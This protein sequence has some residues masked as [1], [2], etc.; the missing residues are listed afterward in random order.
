M[1]TYEVGQTIQWGLTVTDADGALADPG[2]GPTGT[3][4]LPDGTTAAATVAR[5]S[6]GL[7]TATLVSTQAG[8]HRLTWAGSGTN[9]GGFPYTDVADVW[10]SDPRL[11]IGLADARAALNIPATITVNDDELRLHIAAATPV[12]EDI[13]GPVLMGSR[14]EIWSG[15]GKMGLALGAIPTAIT[16]VVEDSV[17]LAASAY[18]FDEDGVLW[19]G[20]AP[21]AGYWSSAS[22]RNVVVTYTVG[23]A[24]IPPN[25]VAAA[26]EEVRFLYQRQQGQRP[27][28]NV[29]E[30]GMAFTP[31]G[32]AVPRFVLELCKPSKAG[33]MPG[34]A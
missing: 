33:R 9:S 20:S 8:R 24:Q 27:T 22:P 7:F 10:P 3:V 16:T 6:I 31:S 19:R 14:V 2:T 21:R 17:T 32:F 5:T 4:T 26:R 23:A 34:F 29:A 12:L 30:G 13:V 18:C 25:L 28:F 15:V 1:A 11:I